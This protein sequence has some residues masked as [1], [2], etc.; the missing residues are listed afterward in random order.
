MRDDT[1][2]LRIT[3]HSGAVISPN[4][5]KRIC[6]VSGKMQT[7]KVRTL[8]MLAGIQAPPD[9]NDLVRALTTHAHLLNAF[10]NYLPSRDASQHKPSKPPAVNKKVISK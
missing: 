2:L 3:T 7:S 10:D 4:I 5:I 6:D 9:D 8:Y 1:K